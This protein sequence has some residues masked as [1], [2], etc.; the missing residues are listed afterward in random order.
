VN[1]RAPL[2]AAGAFVAAAILLVVLFVLPK[3][4]EIG[5]TQDE[6]TAAENQEIVLE[7]ELAALQD[8]QAAALET[9]QQIAAIDDLIPPTAE[10][11]ELFTL[12]QGAAD[13]AAVDFFSFSPGTPVPNLSGTFSTIPSSITVTGS[14]FALDQYLF[15]METLPRAAK[16]L[17]ITVSP[18]AGEETST[19][20]TSTSSLQL[21]MTIDFYTTDTS[22]GPSSVPGPSQPVATTP[23]TGATGATGTTGATEPAGD[24]GAEG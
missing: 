1:R 7:A 12:L 24:T 4:G 15:L 2:I 9:E 18:L 3:M 21:L 13:R 23:P 11:P 6:L 19:S 17:S 22:S 14:Y 5:E 8:A 16:V 10:L 20:T